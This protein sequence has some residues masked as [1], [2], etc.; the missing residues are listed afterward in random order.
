MGEV[1]TEPVFAGL[2]DRRSAVLGRSDLGQRPLDRS[3]QPTVELVEVRDPAFIRGRLEECGGVLHQ[4]PVEVREAALEVGRDEPHG[5]TGG[6]DQLISFLLDASERPLCR[7]ALQ[8]GR[9]Q[10][11]TRGALRHVE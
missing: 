6:G 2:T 8:I 3:R 1:A 9:R 5:L 11:L 4:L 10:D 7:I